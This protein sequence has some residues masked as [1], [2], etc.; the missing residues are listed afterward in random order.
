MALDLRGHGESDRAAGHYEMD[1]MVE[2]L[3][4]LIERL[5]GMVDVVGA[6]MG[7]IV[8]THAASRGFALRRLVIVDAPPKPPGD[9]AKRR[10]VF[11]TPKR[12]RSLEHGVRRFRLIPPDTFA[13]SELI[14][15]IALRSFRQLD[16]GAYG[17]KFDHR[18]FEGE[19]PDPPSGLLESIEVPTLLIRGSHSLLLDEVAAARMASRIPRCR[20][21]TVPQAHHH[22]FLDNPGDFLA[23]VSEFLA[24]G[25]ECDAPESAGG[26]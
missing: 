6:S 23:V 15:S 21:V 9:I 20:L 26:R 19:R 17:L 3:G 1:R 25:D 18:V 10:A 8:A 13:D 5:G 7:G 22:V 24:E 11:G 2:D 16:D 4:A 14:A 12:Y